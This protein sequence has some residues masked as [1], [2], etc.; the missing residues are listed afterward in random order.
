MNVLQRVSKRIKII[1]GKEIDWS[2]HKKSFGNLHPDITFYVIRRSERYA[3]INS[4]FI[5]NMGHIRYALKRGWVPIIDMKNYPN[6]L[7]DDKEVGEKNSWDYYFKQPCSYTLEEVYQSKNVILSDGMPKQVYPN[8][9]MEFFTRPDLIN[10]WHKYFVKYLGFSDELQKKINQKYQQYFGD[11]KDDRVLGVFL[12]GTD[13]L[14]MKPYEHPVQPSI[15]EAIEKTKQVM[16]EKSCQWCF[17]VTEDLNILSEYQKEFGEHL[18]Y[19]K[20][21]ERYGAMQPGQYIAEYT[22]QRENDRYLKG[23]EG[24]TQIGILLQ[25]NCFIGGR[26]S[27]SVAAMVMQPE[28]DYTYFWN[29]GRYGIDD[30]LDNV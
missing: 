22:F 30:I 18:I 27:G 8:D 19:I 24:L 26:T 3:G 9:N 14:S 7:L 29:L 2:E 16:E 11:K 5:S 20:E 10:M 23:M 12:R 4:H 17:L 25:C 15:S 1:F 13:Y 6:A 28:Y 21:Q